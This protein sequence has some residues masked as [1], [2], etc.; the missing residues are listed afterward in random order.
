MFR[1]TFIVTRLRLLC[2]LRRSS[3]T[4]C[5]TMQRHR[6]RITYSIEEEKEM[7]S[8][9]DLLVEFT[10]SYFCGYWGLAA[11]ALCALE[12]VQEIKPRDVLKQQHI[13]STSVAK[14]CSSFDF[15]LLKED[16]SAAWRWLHKYKDQDVCQCTCLLLWLLSSQLSWSKTEE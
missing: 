4:A 13:C 8:R 9:Q 2:I 11:N 6:V 5:L 14:Y 3:V 12:F 1:C 15:H 16:Y 7:K 10:M